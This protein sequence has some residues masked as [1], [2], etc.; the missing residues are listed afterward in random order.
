MELGPRTR[1]SQRI[2]KQVPIVLRWQPAGRDIEDDPATTVLLSKHGC[3]FAP[4][5]PIKLGSQIYVLDPAR[6]KSA[7]A[8][9][10][11]REMSGSAREPKL[12]VEFL[13]TDSFWDVQFSTQSSVAS[14]V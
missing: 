5:M 8:R 2:A 6:G 4:A 9:V 14:R 12:A 13:D 11:Y 7:R 1:R 10:V 3:S